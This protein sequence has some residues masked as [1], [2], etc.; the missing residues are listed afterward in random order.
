MKKQWIK[1]ALSGV[2][3]L[4]LAATGHAGYGAKPTL[5]STTK[6]GDTY[7]TVTGQIAINAPLT[8]AI[9][10]ILDTGIVT[11]WVHNCEKSSV[12]A[13]PAPNDQTLHMVFK[14][15]PPFSARDGYVRF[16]GSHA[17]GRF[18]M[19][20][21][22]ASGPAPS[23]KDVRLRDL[24]GKF[25]IETLGNQQIGVTFQ[26]HIDPSIKPVFAANANVE[27][28][29][30]NTLKNLKQLAEGSYKNKDLSASAKAALGL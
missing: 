14:T 23:G 12:V 21:I 25:V 19:Q 10:V 9:A 6:G 11:R 28:I 13:A 24:R 1:Q 26:L 7:A 18:E 4:A 3:L 16:L 17:G 8:S 29:V 2:V 30:S 20:M 27:G 15:P 5:S 22:E